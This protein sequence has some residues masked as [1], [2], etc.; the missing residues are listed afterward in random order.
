LLPIGLA[1]RRFWWRKAEIARILPIL[2]AA[3]IKLAMAITA[4][5]GN[6]AGGGLPD[7]LSLAQCQ[8]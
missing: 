2:S 6:N 3:L 1:H 5:P 7:D 8:P 4:R